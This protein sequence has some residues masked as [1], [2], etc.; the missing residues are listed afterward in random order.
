VLTDH[1]LA[2]SL[3]RITAPMGYLELLDGDCSDIVDLETFECEY[4]RDVLI[5]Q[6]LTYNLTLAPS[7]IIFFDD[8]KADANPILDLFCRWSIDIEKRLIKVRKQ[9]QRDVCCAML[10][11]MIGST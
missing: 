3:I 6:M 8:S 5:A 11:M 10:T 9:D 4:A 2:D 7:E 1:S